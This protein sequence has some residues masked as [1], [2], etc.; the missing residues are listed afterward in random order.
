MDVNKHIRLISLTPTIPKLAED[1]V[2]AYRMLVLR[3]LEVSRNREPT[4]TA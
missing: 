2:V 1:F 4:C 3:C